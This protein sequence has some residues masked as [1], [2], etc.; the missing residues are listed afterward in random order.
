MK[1]LLPNLS[2]EKNYEILPCS[3]NKQDENTLSVEKHEL[4]G[5]TIESDKT[6]QYASLTVCNQDAE[7]RTVREERPAFD[8]M[9]QTSQRAKCRQRKTF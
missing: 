8:V 4:L 9:M 7:E 2:L 3:S 5:D 1:N 6:L